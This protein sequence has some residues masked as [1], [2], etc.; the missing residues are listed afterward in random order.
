MKQR[1][2]SLPSGTRLDRY[3]IDKTLGGGGFSI[4]YLASDCESGEIVVIKEYIPNRL[5][6][7]RDDQSVAPTSEEE[8]GRFN[9]GRML[10]FQ[11]AS[12]LA[13][14]KHSNIVNVLSF[15]RANGTVYMVMEYQEGKNLQAYLT[16][17]RGNLSEKF[18]R[19]VFPPLLDGLSLIHSKDLLHLDIKPGNIHIRPGGRPLLLDF[20]AVHGFP[21]SRQSQPGQIVS[22]G[23]SPI[24]QYETGGYVGP[25]SDIYAFGATMRACIDG[26]PPPPAQERHERDTLKSARNSFRKRYSDSLLA[27]IDWAMEVDPML[28]PQ[29]TADFRAALLA[30]DAPIDESEETASAFDRLVGSLPWGKG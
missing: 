6:Q 24:E 8:A 21:Q 27:A 15:F 30:E 11:E 18:L 23:F 25:W 19:T 16:T 28:R 14:L 5:A 26:K 2:P 13:T 3:R 10:F 20:G 17:R 4:V 9:R 7:R 22:P 1:P 12:A 29:N